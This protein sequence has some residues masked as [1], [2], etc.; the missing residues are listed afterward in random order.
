MRDQIKSHPAWKGDLTLNEMQEILLGH[1]PY[2]IA[3]SQGIDKHHF[4]LSYVNCDEKV[5]H[6]T[7]K[8]LKFDG[9]MG[10]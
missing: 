1:K 6:H 3:L 9:K 10:V 7:L 5:S 4:F 2:T 8:I